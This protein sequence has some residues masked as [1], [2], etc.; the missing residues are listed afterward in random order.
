VDAKAKASGN[1]RQTSTR[2]LGLFSVLTVTFAVAFAVQAALLVESWRWWQ[3]FWQRMMV[4]NPTDGVPHNNLANMLLRRGRVHEAAPHYAE[5]IRLDPEYKLAIFNMANCTVQLNR[6]PEAAH[7]FK[8]GLKL[9]PDY[10][11]S[12]SN[13][14]ALLENVGDY[15]EALSAYREALRRTGGRDQKAA[16]RIAALH[17]HGIVSASTSPHSID[18]STRDEAAAS[19][20]LALSLDPENV[21]TLFRYGSFL[22]DVASQDDVSSKEASRLTSAAKRHLILATRIN[23]GHA[24]SHNV[25]GI[26][27]GRKNQH[28]DALARFELASL[29]D[30]GR[31]AYRQNFE[32]TA[33]HM[34]SLARPKGSKKSGSQREILRQTQAG[35]KVKKSKKQVE[36]GK[37]RKKAKLS[38]KRPTKSKAPAKRPKTFTVEVDI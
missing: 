38:G 34:K 36:K 4:L 21:D 28:K 24:Q 35:R 37:S 8:R 9:Q 25:L 31:E 14:G 2:V 30:P 11:I 29:L 33:L 10:P 12:L 3:P 19:F 27:A 16:S 7:Y 13:Y 1:R 20:E 15:E 23:P 22:I 17:S 18:D 5:A 26:I 6:Y 32:M